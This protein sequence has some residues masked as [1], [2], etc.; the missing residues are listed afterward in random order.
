MN[1]HTRQREA[2]LKLLRGTY[3]HPTADQIYDRVRKEIPNI[4]KGTVYRNLKVLRETGLVSELNLN[5]TVS[6]F[7]AK[8]ESHYHFR[9]E[10]C[11]R[12]FDID[13]P[14][15]RE[16]DR[17]VALRTGFSISHHQLEFRG[18]CRDCR[19]NNIKG[20]NCLKGGGMNQ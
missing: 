14:V 6:R 8:Q 1:R 2:I 13:E 4:S 16:L 20:Q 7:E 17:R 15:D 10:Q 5:D 3:S 11:G 19:M 9:C 12:V 18:L